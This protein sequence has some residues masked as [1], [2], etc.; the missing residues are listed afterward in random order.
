M[1]LLMPS[2]NTS[3]VR[4]HSNVRQVIYSARDLKRSFHNAI[5][6]ATGKCV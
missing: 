2:S 5:Q 6:Y 1:I 3:L 4:V